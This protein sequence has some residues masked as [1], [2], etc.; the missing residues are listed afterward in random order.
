M[1][2]MMSVLVRGSSSHSRDTSVAGLRR[3]HKT[4]LRVPKCRLS[5]RGLTW[6]IMEKR[7][8][9]QLQVEW[10][11]HVQRSDAQ[12]RGTSTV[13]QPK[14]LLAARSPHADK[15][16][17]AS[18]L[19]STISTPSHLVPGN[20]S[21]F[22]LAYH[23]S[24]LLGPFF[25]APPVLPVLVFNTSSL[26]FYRRHVEVLPRPMPTATHLL[27]LRWSRELRWSRDGLGGLDAFGPAA[28]RIPW[29]ECVAYRLNL[30]QTLLRPI[31]LHPCSS[32]L[33]AYDNHHHR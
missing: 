2:I 13:F 15:P 19:W 9:C 28:E 23:T 31:D 16:K 17:S 33:V 30:W 21:A 7:D 12:L 25:G 3:C 1:T 14:H 32:E 6:K 11:Q 27:Q 8:R 4:C 20:V 29:R 22:S 10:V 5:S 24:C 18:I 26:F